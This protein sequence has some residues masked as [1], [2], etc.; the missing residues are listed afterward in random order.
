[1]KTGQINCTIAYLLICYNAEIKKRIKYRYYKQI[2]II[3][4]NNQIKANRSG[5][6]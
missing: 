4:R 5:I 6:F 3:K 2:K 1:M